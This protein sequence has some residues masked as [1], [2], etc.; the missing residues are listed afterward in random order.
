ME[1]ALANFH[2]GSCPGNCELIAAQVN[3]DI[4]LSFDYF[5]MGVSFP[6]KQLYAYRYE[7][8]TWVGTVGCNLALGARESIDISW[9][10][11]QATPSVR[12]AFDVQ[13]SL[14]YVDNQY[15]LFWLK[16]F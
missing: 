4:K 13:G 2:I 12:P 6:G 15:S 3:L 16:A 8:S 11:A 10:R 5:E 14:R 9:R 1:Q 7:A